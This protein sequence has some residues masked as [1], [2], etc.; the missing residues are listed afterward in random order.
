M[1]QKK[2][3]DYFAMWLSADGSGLDEVFTPDAVYTE[4]WGPE[5]HGAGQIK[6]WFVDW[7]GR[8]RV[9]R[10]DIIGFVEQDENLAV[11]WYFECEYDGV[12]SGFDG[13]TIAEFAPDGRI[14]RLREFQSKAE[15][16][17][18]YGIEE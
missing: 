14:C 4:S 7:V 13:V 8:G 11:E 2:I 17:Y 15:H 18:P 16:E 6:R 10:W 5:Y 12:R 3:R 9:L 1:K